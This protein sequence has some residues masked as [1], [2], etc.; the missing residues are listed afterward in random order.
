MC[1]MAENNLSDA[2]CPAAIFAPAPIIVY[3]RSTHR[4]IGY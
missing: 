1:T 4:E 2:I 3:T